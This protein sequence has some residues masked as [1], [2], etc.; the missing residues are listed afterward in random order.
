[1]SDPA[2]RDVVLLVHPVGRRG[3]SALVAAG[4]LIPPLGPMSLAA[5]LQ[6]AGRPVRFVDEEIDG[7]V[8]EEVLGRPASEAPLLLGISANHS[9]QDRVRAVIAEAR[10]RGSATRIVVGG[11]AAEAFEGFLEAGADAACLGEGDEAILDLAAWARGEQP[12]AGIAGIA[13]AALGSPTRT[14]P[15]PLVPALDALP[16]PSW[17]FYPPDRVRYDN[18]YPPAEHPFATLVTSR[19]CPMRCRYCA[20]PELW[21]HVVRRRTVANVMEEI[22]LLRARYGVR[23]LDVYDDI[24]NLA[25]RWTTE[26]CEALLQRGTPVRWGAYFYPANFDPALLRL[27]QRAGLR[28]LKI[29]V[30]SGSPEIL[31]NIERRR[32]DPRRGPPVP[33]GGLRPRDLLQH[34]LHLRPP[35]GEQ[36]DAPRVR[37]ATSAACGRTRSRSA[38]SSCFPAAPSTATASGSR[39]R[40]TIPRST[41]PSGAPSSATTSGR[42]ASCAAPAGGSCAGS[43]APACGTCSPW[44]AWPLRAAASR[45]TAP[46]APGRR[47]RDDGTVIGRDVAELAVDQLTRNLRRSSIA[48]LGLMVGVGALMAMDTLGRATSFYLTT[49]IERMGQARVVRVRAVGTKGL[50]SAARAFTPAEIERLRQELPHV[51]LVSARVTDWDA[52]VAAGDRKMQGLV[53]GVDQYYFDLFGLEMEDGAAPGPEASARR[54]AVGVLGAELKDRLFGND[55]AVGRICVAD[56]VPVRVIGVLR[57]SMLEEANI[58]L[59]VPLSSALARFRDCRRLDSFYVEA[60]DLAN[61]RTVAAALRGR[62]GSRDPRGVQQHEVRV[63]DTAL[64]KIQD[65]MLVLRVFLLSVGLV[66]LLL[67]SI[68]IMNVFVASLPERTVEIGIRKA[69]GATEGEIAAQ[70]LF[71]AALLCVVA[72]CLGVGLGLVV[73]RAVVQG[74]GRPEMAAFSALR[75]VAVVVFTSVLGSLFALSPALRAARKDVVEAIRNP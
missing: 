65:T 14:A 38:S 52:S 6:R 12:L 27:A 35:G 9:S 41:R 42:P 46:P 28:L 22:D 57:P 20:S 54:A 49:F 32:G 5:A 13:F 30:Q 59:F 39:W 36:G 29:G 25:P 3:R 48:V 47:D 67:G 73:I 11:P 60:D 24:F 34:R 33:G 68:G 66:T 43:A 37:S 75:I 16:F 8:L 63:N 10:R 23:F 7:P 26:F 44:P 17:D 1:M 50:G 71:E 31:R 64:E 18:L 69:V 56:G 58:T 15:R 55:D 53:A 21:R 51:A 45:A 40:W 61:V 70:F 19:G 72:S 4:F 2:G 74:T 62:L